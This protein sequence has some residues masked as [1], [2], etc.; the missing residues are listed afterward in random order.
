[1]EQASAPQIEMASD[2]W[3]R[4]CRALEETGL[5]ALRSTMTHDEID[6]AEGLRH[7]GRMSWLALSGAAENK[8][9]NDPYFWTALD[10]HLKMGGDNPQGLYLS[11]P[12]NPQDTFRIRGSRGSA[13]WVSAILGR[14]PAALGQGLSS[15]GEAFFLPDLEVDPDGKFELL[16]SPEEPASGPANWLR[17]DAWSERVL[18]RQFFPTPDDVEPMQGLTIENRSCPD[19]QPRPLDL[20]SAISMLDRAGAMY[21]RFI[22]M[23]QTEMVEKAKNIF[24]TDIGDPTSTSGGVPGGNAV[25]ARWSLAEDEALLVEVTPPTPCAYW[26]VQVGN[27]WYES[28]DYRR[29]FSGLTCGGAHL[30]EDGS[31]TLVLSQDDPGTA[32]WVETAGHRE[33]HIAIRWQLTE[34]SLPIP[35]CTVV[36]TASVLDRTNLPVV[37]AELRRRQRRALRDSANARFGW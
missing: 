13:I 11:A 18:L 25:T 24:V 1:M 35:R 10:P 12:I 9:S 15:F 23:F 8:D 26:D 31:V 36:K 19:A 29:H 33:G 21:A 4:W 16:I 14:S 20:E 5:A 22:P 3:S 37:S 34:G 27:G 28:F 32:N 2:A 6:I 30:N 17:S 7:L